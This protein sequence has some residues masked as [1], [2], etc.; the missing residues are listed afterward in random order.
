VPV[1][2]PSLTEQPYQHSPSPTRAGERNLLT[3]AFSEF[4]RGSR[5]CVLLTAVYSAR[6]HRCYFQLR[7]LSLPQLL[8]FRLAPCGH[9]SFL[10]RIDS[11]IHLA[12]NTRPTLQM[13]FPAPFPD[14]SVFGYWQISYTVSVRQSRNPGRYHCASQIPLTCSW[15]CSEEPAHSTSSVPATEQPHNFHRMCC[16]PFS[17]WNSRPDL[18]SE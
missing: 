5:R 6:H 1:R 2:R 17:T 14:H 12:V 15:T 10:R 18:A 3:T 8:V 13:L 9:L 11:N 7:L 16:R 4:R